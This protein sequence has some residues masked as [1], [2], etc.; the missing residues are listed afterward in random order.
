MVPIFRW[1][2]IATAMISHDP[3]IEKLMRDEE[4]KVSS[5]RGMKPLAHDAAQAACC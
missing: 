4:L 5:F 1:T 2:S 3:R